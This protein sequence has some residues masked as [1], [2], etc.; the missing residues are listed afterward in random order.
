M[1]IHKTPTS[2]AGKSPTQDQIVGAD[3][4]IDVRW[5]AH[6]VSRQDREKTA[7]HRGCVLCCCRA[8]DAGLTHARTS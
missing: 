2:T 6:A 7:G 5:H 3:N 1:Q 8:H 4:L